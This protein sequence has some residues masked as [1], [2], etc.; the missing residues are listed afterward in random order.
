MKNKITA[1]MSATVALLSMASIAQAN[2][3]FSVDFSSAS[4]YSEG[5]LVG[6]KGWVIEGSSL[7]AEV[8]A[9]PASPVG[10]DHVLTLVGPGGSN[11][12][13]NYLVFTDTPLTD[14]FSMDV[15]MMRSSSYS[16]RE[17]YISLTNSSSLGNGLMIGF[18]DDKFFYRN[19][20]TYVTT[21]QSYNAN[22]WYRFHVDVDPS[23][24]KF[25]LTIFDQD[26]EVVISTITDIGFRGGSVVSSIDVLRITQQPGSG[27]T[28]YY[29]G[30]VTMSTIPEPGAY[31]LGM[32]GLIGALAAFRRFRRQES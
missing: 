2:D 25:S 26:D 19:G 21:E 14:P 29:V 13:R 30:G 28:T 23:A 1:I 16:I 22:T 12:V 20:E 5:A 9:T 11:P 32:A 8:T 15:W 3:L 17:S 27:N 4:G 31:A 24:S 10:S 18:D 7:S 6:Q